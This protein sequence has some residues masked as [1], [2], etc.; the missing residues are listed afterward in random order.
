[1]GRGTTGVGEWVAPTIGCKTGSRI[2]Q[3]GEYSQCFV[4]TYKWKVTFKTVLIFFFLFR[5]VPV[6]YE[7]PRPGTKKTNKKSLIYD[8]VPTSAIQQNDPVKERIYSFCHILLHRVR[9]QE[10]GHSSRVVQ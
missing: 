8:V 3:H 9:S 6:A 1:M 5:T 2:V 10:L 4:I 7:V